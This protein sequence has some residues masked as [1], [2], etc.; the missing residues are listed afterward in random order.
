M[1][2]STE[3]GIKLD[4]EVSQAIP[5]CDLLAIFH[6]L[7]R[8]KRLVIHRKSSLRCGGVQAG[9][10]AFNQIGVANYLYYQ[11]LEAVDP[12]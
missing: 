5:L 1:V 7:V 8:L 9:P 6:L 12:T 3:Y 10:G 11:S 2:P 4:F